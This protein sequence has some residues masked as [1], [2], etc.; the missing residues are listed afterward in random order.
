MFVEFLKEMIKEKTYYKKFGNVMEIWQEK[1]KNTGKP[2]FIIKLLGTDDDSQD[3]CKAFDELVFSDDLEKYRQV[4]GF[5]N[6]KG[7]KIFCQ[8]VN[9]YLDKKRKRK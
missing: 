1:E 3:E 8:R 6:D 9:N 5:L 7:N 2:Y 4:N